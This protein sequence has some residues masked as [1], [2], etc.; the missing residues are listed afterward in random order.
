MAE[1][2]Q[3]VEHAVTGSLATIYTVPAST[4]SVVVGFQIANVHASNACWV[5][6]KK[7]SSGGGTNKSLC[8]QISI[9]VNDSFNPIQGKLFLEAGEFIQVQGESASSLEVVMSVLE[10][11]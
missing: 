3:N 2:Y 1:S 6:V 7:F 4:S 5:T 8:N 9:P 11:T 10:L